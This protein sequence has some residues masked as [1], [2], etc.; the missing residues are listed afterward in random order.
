M[1]L[2]CAFTHFLHFL[3]PFLAPLLPFLLPFQLN[4]N[5]LHPGLKKQTSLLSARSSRVM[6]EPGVARGGLRVLVSS[7]GKN[8]S[9]PG[10][11]GPRGG[12]IHPASWS[13]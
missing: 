6:G 13:Y 10:G 8:S 5:L 1:P 4:G 2:A 7:L 3:R 11:W 9:L 12:G